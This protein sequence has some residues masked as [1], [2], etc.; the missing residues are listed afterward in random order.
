MNS[1]LR[2]AL[3]VN[4]FALMCVS[5]SVTTGTGI[6]PAQPLSIRLYDQAQTPA[7]VLQSATDQA[8]WPFRAT[9]IRISWE[10]PSTESSEDQDTNMTSPRFQQP[11]TRGYIVARL[12]GSTP[13][14]FHLPF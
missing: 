13:G 10:C 6:T 11:D 3:I 4:T 7:R 14:S 8:R 5:G 1:S 9:R 2:L 12:M